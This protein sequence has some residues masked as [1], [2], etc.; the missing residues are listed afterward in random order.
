MRGEISE[1]TAA[2]IKYLAKQVASVTS[3]PTNTLTNNPE[4]SRQQQPH[5]YATSADPFNMSGLFSGHD[6]KKAEATARTRIENRQRKK[7]WREQNEDRN[8]DNDLR[9]RV[10]KRA[11]KLFGTEDTE[12][13]TRWIDAEFRKR[14]EKRK[15]KEGHRPKSVLTDYEVDS[16][17]IIRASGTQDFV[18]YLMQNLEFFMLGKGNMQEEVLQELE[19][20][21]ELVRSIAGTIVGDAEQQMQQQQMA[22]EQMQKQDQKRIQNAVSPLQVSG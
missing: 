13:K 3:G 10:N 7:R 17:E 21:L 11:A 12:V 9:C 20:H 16:S 8:K 19:R 5:Q 14:Q 18:G 2:A 15:S 6:L 22:F 4:S 1:E